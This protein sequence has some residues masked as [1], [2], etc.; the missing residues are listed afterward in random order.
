MPPILN[1]R[2]T[3]QLDGPIVVFL[4]GIRINKWWDVRTWIPVF[5]AMPRMI[6][7]LHKHPEIGFLHA[8]MF[9]TPPRAL[10][11]QYWRSYDDLERFARD[12]DKTHFPAWRAYNKLARGK[13]SV[14]IWH[15]TYVIDPGKAEAVYDGM[16][17]FGLAAATTLRDVDAATESARARLDGGRR[18]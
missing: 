3:A 10:M 16:P 9:F 15:E 1:R 12:P 4:I 14:G 13:G 6:S 2:V 5:L 7:E 18:P 8:E 17:R 11:V